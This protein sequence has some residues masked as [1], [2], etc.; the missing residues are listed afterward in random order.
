MNREVHVRFWEG[1]GVRFPRATRRALRTQPLQFERK[2]CFIED[3]GGP[4]EV[5]LQEQTSNR[6]KLRG[7]RVLVVSVEEKAEQHFVRCESRRR[8][9]VNR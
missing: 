5:G 6:L 8:T 3:E 7:L 1:L 9:Q 4:L 2:R